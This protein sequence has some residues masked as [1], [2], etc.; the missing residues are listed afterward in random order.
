VVLD[1]LA[2]K[3]KKKKGKISIN[4]LGRSYLRRLS[5]IWC[6]IS[7]LEREKGNEDN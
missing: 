5:Y 7:Y 6:G 4:S 1:H 3:K 2:K